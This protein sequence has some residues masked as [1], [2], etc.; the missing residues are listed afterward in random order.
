MAPENFLLLTIKYQGN[1]KIAII[2]ILYIP[3][4]PG[5]G[6][7]SSPPLANRPFESLI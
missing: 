5:K 3:R 2:K 6:M 4:K 7:D 1:I